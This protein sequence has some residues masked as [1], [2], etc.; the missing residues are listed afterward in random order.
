MSAHAMRAA[1][2]IGWPIAHSKSP[3]I[4]HFWLEKLGIDGDYSRFAVEP[5][6]L[7]QAMQGLQAL[8]LSGVNVTVPHK[9]AILAL[10]DSVSPAAQQ[11][12]AVNLVTVTEDGRLRG[13]NSDVDGVLEALPP[14]QLPAGGRVCLIGA[15]G[16][17]RA[18]MAAFS[19]R[20]VAQ[21]ALVVRN[22]A[23][24]AALLQEFAIEGRVWPFA[25]AAEALA[26]ADAVV[27]ATTLGMTGAQS[28]PA[29][30]LQGLAGLAPSASVFDMVYAP[31]ETPLLGAARRRGLRAVDGLV[32]LVGQAASA[33]RQLFGAEP[34]RL[35]DDELRQRLLG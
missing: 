34:P 14:A 18:A 19:R 25:H 9:V 23:K 30:V 1:G 7:P 2:V 4:H 31:I 16:A 35:Y 27:N 33:F 21:V 28:M 20:Q 8:G 10:L 24:G 3:V 26:G 12:G 15:G 6:H 29:T 17:A 32:M 22:P 11:V 5:G 13:D